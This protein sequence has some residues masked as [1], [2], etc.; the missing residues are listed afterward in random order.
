MDSLTGKEFN[1]KYKGTN[2]YKFINDTY[3]HYDFKYTNGLNIDTKPFNATCKN[4]LYF[5]DTINLAIWMYFGYMYKVE[6]PN[7]ASVCIYND[8]FK[9]D[10][11]IVDLNKKILDL[12][13]EEDIV[14]KAIKKMLML[15]DM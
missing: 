12:V 15:Y 10:M 3:T 13:L 6:I 2:F 4:G 14:E 9:S 1:E 8:R 7:D 11:L 5:T